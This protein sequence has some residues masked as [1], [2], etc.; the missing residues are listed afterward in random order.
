MNSIF[1]LI[2]RR[3][4]AP[5]IS[6][7][8]SF[9]VA[10]VGLTMMPGIDAAG[11]PWQIS[12]FEA[13]YVISYTATTIGFGELPYPFSNEQRMWMTF[14]IYLTVIP[15]IYA[16][17]SII[18]LFQDA[19]LRHAITS[20]RFAGS[21]TKLHEPFYLVCGYGET[22]SLL[23]KALDRNELRVVVVELK[24]D[25]INELELEDYQFSIPCLCADAKLPEILLKAGLRNPMCQGVAALTNDDHAN[26]AIAVAVKL[27]NP[28]LMVVARAEND[29]TAANMASFGTDHIINPFTLFGEHLAIEM[30]ALGTYLLHEWLTGV[31]GDAVKAPACPPIGKWIVCGYGRFGKSVVENLHLEKNTTVIIEADPVLTQCDD[32]IVGDGTEA[33]TLYE[34]GIESAVGI[35][36]G[37]NDDINN[38]SIVM[39][40]YEINPHLFVV[41]RKNKH[42]NDP[43]FEHFNADIAMDPSNIIAHECLAHMVSPLLAQFLLLSRSQ[44]N[45]WANQLIS[46]LV[47]TIGEAI[48]ETWAITINHQQAPAIMDLLDQ[49]HIISLDTITRDPVNREES[50]T[51]VPLMLHR[52]NRN[53]L[54]PEPSVQLAEGDRIL[55]C[56]HDNAKAVMGFTLADHKT[57][58]FIIH[59][60]AV[61]DNAVWRR[62]MDL[63]NKKPA[64]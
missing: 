44:S 20:S 40:A 19:G 62:L 51:V 54:L 25:R 47:E 23:V 50:L 61:S 8:I 30:H 56:G 13:F 18:T 42:Y 28:S 24:Q 3:M 33:V 7:I 1:F 58:S 36:A 2:L 5:L 4:R 46:R 49:G 59:G 63:L 48:P 21:V 57:L 41:I 15:W 34:A 11:Q 35:V 53:T 10:V 31:P 39:T 45:D 14:S 26:L 38:L 27:I 6:I 29:K 22:G 52:D 16:I 17:G 9:A 32:C 12:I 60:Y 43:L 64:P 37:T 55:L